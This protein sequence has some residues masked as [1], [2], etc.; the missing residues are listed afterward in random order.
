MQTNMQTNMPTQEQ[1]EKWNSIVPEHILRVE[2]QHRNSTALTQYGCSE[3][4]NRML[5]PDIR[6]M[7]QDMIIHQNMLDSVYKFFRYMYCP[8]PNYLLEQAYANVQSGWWGN[9][10]Y[11][12]VDKVFDEFYERIDANT[13]RMRPKH[14][15]TTLVVPNLIRSY[16]DDDDDDVDE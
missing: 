5:G 7:L 11:A 14:R 1:I 16:D 3:Y 15:F 2:E 8:D 6:Q 9:V 12:D 10:T 13:Y 4:I